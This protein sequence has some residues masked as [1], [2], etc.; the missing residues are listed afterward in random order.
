MSSG[1]YDWP[2]PLE[3]KVPL[4]LPYFDSSES[5]FLNRVMESGWIGA[6]AH[7]IHQSESEFNHFF[8]SHSTLVANGS[9]ALMLA[10]KSLQVK[11]KDEVIVPALTYAATASSVINVGATPVFC[12]V[13]PNSWQIS[14]DS[15]SRMISERTKA[16]IVPHLYGLPADMDQI[17]R[18]ARQRN[19][20][21]IEDAAESFGAK[22]KDAFVGTFGNIGTF[23]FFPNKLITSGEGGLCITQDFKLSARMK[24]LRG[25]GADPTKRYYFLEPGYN[26][27]ITALQVAVLRAQFAKVD[28]LWGMREKSEKNH[29]EQLKDVVDIPTASYP[30]IRAPWIFSCVL[31]S[32]SSSQKEKIIEGL[33]KKGIETRPIFYPLPEMPAFRGFVSDSYPNSSSISAAGFS[34]PTG[35]HVSEESFKSISDE[36]HKYASC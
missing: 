24:L 13:E 15:F 33:A 5:E 34:L 36:V 16:V 14:P 11:P 26:F 6:G 7:E 28:L 1:P 32:G 3:L 30:L 17:L 10:L 9:V 22:Y 29:W 27:R 18:I 35:S 23:S 20:L 2:Q 19:I 4:A 21:V 25:Q 12:D 8:S 31:K